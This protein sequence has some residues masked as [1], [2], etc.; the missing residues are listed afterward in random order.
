[1][2]Q[3]K[4]SSNKTK[5]SQN[6]GVFF[7]NFQTMVGLNDLIGLFQAKRLCD[8]PIQS[9]TSVRSGFSASTKYHH[10]M[11]KRC[12]K[13]P[14]SS[15]SSPDFS[16]TAFSAV[17]WL[18]CP[19][20]LIILPKCQDQCYLIYFCGFLILLQHNQQDSKIYFL[21]SNIKKIHFFPNK[22]FILGIVITKSNRYYF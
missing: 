14:C 12:R 22:R 20:K 2:L 1:M 3:I 10:L 13:S 16:P 11:A 21:Q 19:K 6:F 8:S 7:W 18:L 9:V 4:E 5:N 17:P 15:T